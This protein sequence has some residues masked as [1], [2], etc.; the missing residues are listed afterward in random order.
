MAMLNNHRNKKVRRSAA[1][2]AF[3][4]L[5]AFRQWRRAHRRKLHR[6]GLP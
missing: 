6:L 1:V 4:M 2:A 5:A 3:A